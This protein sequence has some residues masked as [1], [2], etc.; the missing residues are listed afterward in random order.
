[1][2]YSLHYEIRW[3]FEVLWYYTPAKKCLGLFTLL[4]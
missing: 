4:H 2:M 3:A 1:M